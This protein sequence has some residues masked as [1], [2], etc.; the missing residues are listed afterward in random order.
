MDKKA[1]PKLKDRKVKEKEKKTAKKGK[2][3]KTVKNTGAQIDEGKR[4]N[5]SSQPG[6]NR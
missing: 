5:F 6:P 4:R 3:K 2:E 1:N